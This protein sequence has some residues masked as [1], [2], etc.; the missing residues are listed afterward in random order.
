MAVHPWS[1]FF[2]GFTF[3]TCLWPASMSTLVNWLSLCFKLSGGV[4][5]LSSTCVAKS[6]QITSLVFHLGAA[7]LGLV[8]ETDSLIFARHT[9]WSDPRLS[10]TV[11]LTFLSEAWL[12]KRSGVLP[13]PAPRL[14]RVRVTSLTVLR[15]QS[16]C[17]PFFYSFTSAVRWLHC[18][19]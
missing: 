17:D 9:E 13:V 10:P 12:M 4:P 11:H 3:P 18:V 8:M 6:S 1:S 7:G 14:I 5:R 2:G 19:P 16:V 15:L